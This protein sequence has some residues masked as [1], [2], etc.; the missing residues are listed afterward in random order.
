MRTEDLQGVAFREWVLNYIQ[1]STI[2]SL[3][4]YNHIWN[5]SCAYRRTGIDYLT[6]E[7][8]NSTS[9]PLN[10]IGTNIGQVWHRQQKGVYWLRF[11]RPQFFSPLA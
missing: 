10:A 2:I 6:P 3:F 11:D 8:V 5:V 4:K 1:F 9:N 7:G